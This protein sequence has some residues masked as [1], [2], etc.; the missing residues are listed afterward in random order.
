[1]SAF[2]KGVLVCFGETGGKNIGD[3]V[4][5]I[6]SAQFSGP[7]AVNVDRES[8]DSYSGAPLKLVMNA[9]FM[10][11]PERFPPSKAIK[12]LFVSF[13]VRPTIER[14]FF[15]ER[16]IAYLRAHEPI[17][18]R[19]TDA[20]EM[21]ERHGI[22]AEFTSCVTLTLGET[23]RHVE[24]DSPPVFVDPYFPHIGKKTGKAA[25]VARLARRLPLILRHLPSVLRLAPRF[26]VFRAW[27]WIRRF[28][29]R[30]L[31]VADF[32]RAYLPLF[33]M[34]VLLA[35]EYISHKVSKERYPDEKALF[36]C[37]EGLL[38]RYERAPFVVTSRLH[39]ALPCVAMGTPVWVV[40]HP[41]V[42][43]GRFGGNDAF[44]NVL[45]CGQDGKIRSPSPIASKDGRIHL[46]TRPPVRTEHLPFAR[47]MAERMREFLKEDDDEP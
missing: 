43:S 22:K 41:S 46:D 35:A 20:V 37:A 25:M 33:D 21:M 24:A 30:C 29:V 10:H 7:D 16:T 39:C 38:H 17:G 19:S 36:N 3:Y 15:T 31:Y 13:H 9:W 23:F 8:L 12:P 45:S 27:P 32:L 6:A 14:E 26:K 1:M 42:T 18:C 44:F 47:R 11:H 34:K 5:S 2:K 4:Q 28:P 40:L